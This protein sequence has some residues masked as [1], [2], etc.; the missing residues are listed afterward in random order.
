MDAET[1]EPEAR[2]RHSAASA[3][4]DGLLD[5]PVMQAERLVGQM[6]ERVA[7]EDWEALAG[8]ATALRQA[9]QQLDLGVLS[10]G[11]GQSRAGLEALAARLFEVERRHS[12]VIVAL[13]AARDRTAAELATVMEGHRGANRYLLAAGGT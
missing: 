5:G 9:L 1:I 12:E 11:G 2:R 13:T 8:L 7:A 6:E 3:E 4:S 10:Q